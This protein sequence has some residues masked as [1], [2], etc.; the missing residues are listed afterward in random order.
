MSA[1]DIRQNGTYQNIRMRKVIYPGFTDLLGK[2]HWS[3]THRSVGQDAS[4]K[5]GSPSE[6][7]SKR[8]RRAFVGSAIRPEALASCSP[9]H[10]KPY[11]PCLTFIMRPQVS[12]NT[13]K[14]VTAGFP[15]ASRELIVG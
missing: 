12:R 2:V 7:R 14:N 1:A 6:S 11:I 10:K 4:D 5:L 15:L 3:G 9:S 13:Q 8:I